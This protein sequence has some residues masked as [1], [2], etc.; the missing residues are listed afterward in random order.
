[1][2]I[3][4]DGNTFTIIKSNKSINIEV[5]DIH[6]NTY[7]TCITIDYL[8]DH[9][10]ID[11][12]YSEI[13][14]CFEKEINYN[15]ELIYINKELAINFMFY[16]EMFEVIVFS[17]KVFNDLQTAEINKLKIKVKSLENKLSKYIK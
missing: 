8:E 9:F 13:M 17:P 16:D 2:S 12:F 14:K 4:I 3:V 7:E 5:F 11:Q 10:N 6:G 15:M 1:M